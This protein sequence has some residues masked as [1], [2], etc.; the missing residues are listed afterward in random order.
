MRLV[1]GLGNPGI[2][3]AKNRHNIGFQV[4]DVLAARHNFSFDK[5]SMHALWGKGRIKDYEVLLAKPQTY[6]N[7]SGKSVLEMVQFYKIDPKR[8]LLVVTDDLDLPLGKMRLRPNG[9]SGGQNGLKDILNVLAT[10]DVPRL[11]VGVGRPQRG[12]PRDYLL[13]DFAREEMPMLE[14]MHI[15]AADAIELWLAEDLTKAMNKF[16]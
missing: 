8:D 11:R 16:N 7:L 15:R 9:S 10:N 13:N 6:M 2:T 14:Q 4:L 1:V 5:K 12:N 3:Y